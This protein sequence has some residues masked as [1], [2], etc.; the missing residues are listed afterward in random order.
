M[1]LQKKNIK[2]NSIFIS[3]DYKIF[4]SKNIFYSLRPY[5]YNIILLFKLDQTV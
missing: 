2:Q 4:F 5:K 3:D 1:I